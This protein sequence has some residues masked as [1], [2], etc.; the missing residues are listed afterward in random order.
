MQYLVS[1]PVPDAHNGSAKDTARPGKVGVQGMT[2]E[3]Q[4]VG[5]RLAA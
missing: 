2:H 4:G 5:W 3:M 1:A